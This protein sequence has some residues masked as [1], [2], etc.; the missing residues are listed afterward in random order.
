MPVFK[1]SIKHKEK[2]KDAFSYVE[3]IP[4]IKKPKKRKSDAL[5]LR[6]SEDTILPRLKKSKITINLLETLKLGSKS[7]DEPGFR[8]ILT[9]NYPSFLNLGQY[10]SQ[11]CG[12]SGDC[13]FQSISFLINAIKATLH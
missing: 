13:L 4:K 3:S 10:R 1:N 11:D 7:I 9:Q 6:I 2:M 5:D 8:D 12:S